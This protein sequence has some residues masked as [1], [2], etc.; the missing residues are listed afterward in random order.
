MCT[1]ALKEASV[2]LLSCQWRRIKR[3]SKKVLNFQQLHPFMLKD[4]GEAVMFIKGTLII[5][6]LLA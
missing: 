6:V 3:F 2:E 1:A 5:K 4:V